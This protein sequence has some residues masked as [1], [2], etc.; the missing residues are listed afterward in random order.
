MCC[1]RCEAWWVHSGQQQQQPSIGVMALLRYV[2]EV[3]VWWFTKHLPLRCLQGSAAEV[4]PGYWCTQGI[5]VQ[6]MQFNQACGGRLLL[7]EGHLNRQ[8]QQQQHRARSD[9]GVC[10]V[11]CSSNGWLLVSS[12]GQHC[13]WNNA[14]CH[15]SWF[16]RASQR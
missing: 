8:Q 10:L 9:K 3:C 14:G 13:Q 4:Y 2:C 1:V 5:G 15:C 16:T 6:P 11:M 12:M 7:I